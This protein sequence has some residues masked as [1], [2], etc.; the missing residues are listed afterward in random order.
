MPIYLSPPAA[1]G[2]VIMNAFA[3]P[4]QHLLGGIRGQLSPGA[5][6]RLDHLID[7][8]G[9]PL[10]ALK[11]VPA[12]DILDQAEREAL[13]AV[14]R[15]PIDDTALFHPSLVIILK[16][17][18]LCNLRCTYCNSWRAGPG[19]VMTFDT[20]ALLMRTAL[21]TSGLRKLQI[22]W[23]GG[24][25]TLLPLALMR[26]ALWLQERYRPAGVTVDN[27][28][29][30]NA[31]RLTPKWVDFLRAHRVSVGVSIDASPEVHDRRRLTKNGRGTWQATLDGMKRLRAA[32]VP[33]GVLAVVDEHA[34][35]IGA[36]RYL[37]QLDALDVRGVAL[38]NA[39]PA[40]EA[41]RP[42]SD[43]YLEWD[44]FQ[45]FARALF[46]IWWPRYRTRFGI[47][48]LEAL[49]DAVRG[50]AHGLCIYAGNCMGRYLT[51]EPDGRLSACEKYVGNA[52]YAFGTLQESGIASLLTRSP[53]LP[54]A[55]AVVD[56][57]KARAAAVCDH[58]RYC[59][60]GC[61]HDD[62]NNG[63]FGRQS[64]GCCGMKGLIDD[65]KAAVQ[66]E[67][68]DDRSNADHPARSPCRRRTSRISGAK[69]RARRLMSTNSN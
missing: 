58:Y 22:V 40:N 32:K 5:F 17:T 49:V 57:Q 51:V 25:V 50:K 53:N 23:H 31:T 42:N 26:K 8:Y 37:A 36:E 29:Q 6:G 68:D 48:E 41:D 47:R 66:K 24:E 2:L 30:T 9:R 60:G 52:D 44:H 56:A 54:R 12:A 65:I 34:I 27:C 62:L 20:L 18:R 64:G 13:A 46:A 21:S 33:F 69:P 35:A 39:L 67:E 14:E 55:I 7:D 11:T 45:A 59:H 1:S 61:P 28:I 3:D 10:L 4:L 38:L 15:R 63:R 19:Q 16:A 43:A